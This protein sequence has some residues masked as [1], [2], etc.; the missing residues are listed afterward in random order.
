M[1][2]LALVTLLAVA[3]SWL[4]SVDHR[5]DEA[6][7]RAMIAGRQPVD[8]LVGGPD[9]SRPT[10]PATSPGPGDSIRTVPWRK[11]PVERL[12][13]IAKGSSARPMPSW[14]PKSEIEEEA[15]ARPDASGQR[16]LVGRLSASEERAR[17]DLRK[18]VEREVADWLAADAPPTWKPPARAI[19]AM[20]RGAHVQQV[21]RS[22][23]PSTGEFAPEAEAPPTAD[24]PGLDDLYTLYRAGQLVDFSP[25]RRARLVEMYHHDLATW[26]MQRLGGGLALALVGLV[27][28]TG[29]IRADEATKGYYTNRL[30]LAAAVGLGAA[31][32]AA[33]RMLA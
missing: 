22:L 14:F 20:V 32:V 9:D 6:A 2:K 28:L 17:Q 25:A 13:R 16:V 23:K 27:M 5:R 3:A 29:Y 1:K 21:T 24:M 30:R 31:G 7:V 11:A 12:K 33:Y 19:D 26:R 15:K 10:P 8:R 18:A 4:L